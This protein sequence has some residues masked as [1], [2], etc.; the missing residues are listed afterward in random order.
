MYYCWDIHTVLKKNLQSL[1]TANTV[2]V[3]IRISIVPVQVYKA[4]YLSYGTQ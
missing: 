2:T 4:I 1:P 3:R